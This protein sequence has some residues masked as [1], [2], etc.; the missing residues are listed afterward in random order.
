ML[1]DS[2]AVTSMTIA[3]QSDSSSF[4]ALITYLNIIYGFL[5]DEIIFHQP[6][7]WLELVS[8]VVIFI[9]I[10]GVAV[11]K[12]RQSRKATKLQEEQTV[13]LQKTAE[14]SCKDAIE[15]KE[16]TE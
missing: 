11:Y 8:A 7:T 9:V 14:N 2:L 13:A 12:Y 3:F 15:A 4:V 1:F 6:F 5:A 10:V 16:K